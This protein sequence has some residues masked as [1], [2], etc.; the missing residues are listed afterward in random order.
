MLSGLIFR[1]PAPGPSRIPTLSI[2]VA[3]IAAT[4]TALLFALQGA[5]G[6]NKALPWCGRGDYSLEVRPWRSH[7]KILVAVGIVTTKTSPC[8]LKGSARVAVSSRHGRVVR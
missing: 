6:A 7:G 8:T 5:A 4:A 3:V 2:R 1:K